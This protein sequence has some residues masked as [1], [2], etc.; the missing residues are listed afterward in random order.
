MNTTPTYVIVVYSRACG[1]RPIRPVLRRDVG[2]RRRFI[3]AD[4]QTLG[5]HANLSLS[6]RCSRRFDVRNEGSASH[7]HAVYDCITIPAR[8]HCGHTMQTS[9]K[10]AIGRCIDLYSETSYV[11]FN[12]LV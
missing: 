5:G 8:Q 1:E 11:A 2:A 3:D 10:V 6:Q 4:R 12:A 9:D 7:P